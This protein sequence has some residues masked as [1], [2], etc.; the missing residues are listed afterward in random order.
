[1]VFRMVQIIRVF[2]TGLITKTV[3]TSYTSQYNT[4][5]KTLDVGLVGSM[6]GVGVR[7]RKLALMLGCD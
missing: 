4:K 7:F 6:V 1:M 3:N 5:F 2:G